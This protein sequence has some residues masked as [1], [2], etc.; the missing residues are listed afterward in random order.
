MKRIIFL[1]AGIA[2]CST[3][4]AQI[5]VK[6]SSQQFIEDAVH[7]GILLLRQEYQLE[8]TTTMKRYTWN[9]QP[10]FGSALSLC[11]IAEDGYVTT[12]RAL[13]PWEYDAKFDKYRDSVYRPIRTDTYVKSIRDKSWRPVGS[14]N[15]AAERPLAVDEWKTADDSLFHRK[16]FIADTLP[17]EKD[18]WLIWLT[19]SE[20]DTIESEQLTLVSYRHKL[21]LKAEAGTFEIPAPTTQRHVIGGIYAVPAYPG[22][23]RIEL[24]LVGIVVNK[25]DKWKLV[26]YCTAADSRAS[27]TDA[28][29]LTPSEGDNR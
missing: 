5:F 12:D 7:E 11:V 14:M 3:A 1:L 9:K 6:S 8:D 24:R 4:A 26:R 23:G 21:D 22:I 18:G 29:T 13:R 2:A 16:G 25:D 19:A 17:G 28:G 27:D 20:P 15:P 10:D